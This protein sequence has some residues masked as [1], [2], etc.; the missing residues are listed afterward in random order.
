MKKIRARK[1]TIIVSMLSQDTTEDGKH[2]IDPETG[3]IL[4]REV[5]QPI[6]IAVAS[7][8]EQIPPGSKVVTVCDL[9]EQY[10]WQGMKVQLVKVA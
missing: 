5:H 9:G 3:L 8:V 2:P 7:G 10:K 4:G 6:G 1:G